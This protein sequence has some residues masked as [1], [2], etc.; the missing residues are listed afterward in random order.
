[1]QAGAPLNDD[2]VE[3]RAQ[4]V[5]EVAKKGASL[6]PGSRNAVEVSAID[7]HIVTVQTAAGVMCA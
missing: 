5:Q 1:M 7:P 4:H 6:L 2:S 3:V